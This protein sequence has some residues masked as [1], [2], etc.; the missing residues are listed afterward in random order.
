MPARVDLLTQN[1]LGIESFL[2]TGGAYQGSVRTDRGRLL[3]VVPG[4]SAKSASGWL[5]DRFRHWRNQV[6]VVVIDPAPE[7]PFPLPKDKNNRM[8]QEENRVVLEV[9]SARHWVQALEFVVNIVAGGDDFPG[10]GPR[11]VAVRPDGREEVVGRYSSMRRARRAADDLRRELIELGFASWGN[12]HH[13]SQEFTLD[14][15]T[16]GP[17]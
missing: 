2:Q 12:V 3:G 9:R 10:E 7:H 6:A 15:E 1:G 5:D 11:V 13:L 8:D 4:R 14:G 17:S 16:P